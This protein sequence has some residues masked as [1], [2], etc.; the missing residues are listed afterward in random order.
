MDEGARE[1]IAKAFRNANQVRLGIA[2]REVLRSAAFSE[3]STEIP[4]QHAEG[5]A[6]HYSDRLLVLL[7]YK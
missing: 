2:C 6:E 4:R 3:A 5:L 7:C 1:A